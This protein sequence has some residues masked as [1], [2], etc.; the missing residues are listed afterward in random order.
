MKILDFEAASEFVDAVQ[1]QVRD[2]TLSHPRKWFFEHFHAFVANNYKSILDNKSSH[3]VE[4]RKHPIIAK[5]AA[6]QP[7]F[8]D[9]IPEPVRQKDD[10][11]SLYNELGPRRGGRERYFYHI[12]FWMLCK[13]ADEP[14]TVAISSKQF[15]GSFEN[16]FGFPLPMT[17]AEA[18]EKYSAFRKSGSRSAMPSEEDGFARQQHSQDQSAATQQEPTA[19]SDEEAVVEDDLKKAQWAEQVLGTPRNVPKSTIHWIAEQQYERGVLTH[20]IIEEAARVL[21]DDRYRD[22]PK[23]ADE[24]ERDR[25][26]NSFLREALD[27]MKA[28]ESKD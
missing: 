2:R 1:Q 21:L 6:E 17:G 18:K 26:V 9:E 25:I 4:A 16:Y 24:V 23:S 20:E 22:I 7:A 14:E 8:L 27:A 11:R 3:Y 28:R 15:G 5:I 19:A 10:F 13:F 12:Q